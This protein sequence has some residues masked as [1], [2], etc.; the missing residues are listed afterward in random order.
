MDEAFGELRSLLHAPPE[1][2]VHAWEELTALF[3]KGLAR[4]RTRTLEQWM[5]Y[6]LSALDGSWP[7][8]VR[9]APK[10]WL[11]AHVCGYS[12]APLLR[13]ATTLDLTTRRKTTFERVCKTKGLEHIR[14][15]EWNAGTF[16][17]HHGKALRRARS[18]RHIKEFSVRSAKFT[19]N[20]SKALMSAPFLP[21]L[22]ALTFSNAVLQPRALTMLEAGFTTSLRSLTIESVRVSSA[23]TLDWR[24]LSESK[25]PGLRHL[26]VAD[27]WHL[28]DTL[29]TILGAPFIGR[30][31]VLDIARST[32]P[33]GVHAAGTLEHLDAPTRAPAF[34]AS[35]I[36]A[37]L[38]GAGMNP[39]RVARAL[40]SLQCRGSNAAANSTRRR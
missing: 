12:G 34:E 31:D 27:S 22:E 30:L 17:G 36:E 32:G 18:L 26:S 16:M 38:R 25:L 11:T 28:G 1:A 15:V 40:A 24:P 2:R 33:V 23:H 39:P 8:A 3:S 19:T 35:D 21:G 9:V 4:E 29:R 37:A 20:G 7:D 10:S 6:A 13:L 14:R 5:P